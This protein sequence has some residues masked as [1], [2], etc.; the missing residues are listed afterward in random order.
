MQH[1]G[2][3]ISTKR[4]REYNVIKRNLLFIGLKSYIKSH[5]C[6]TY[7]NEISCTLCRGHSQRKP[8]AIICLFIF[9][10]RC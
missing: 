7:H 10:D 8:I 5:S 4:K 9:I 2:K 3:T 6:I 1:F